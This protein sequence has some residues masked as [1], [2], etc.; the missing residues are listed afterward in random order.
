M[1]RRAT[2]RRLLTIP[3]ALGLA[4][5]PAHRCGAQPSVLAHAD[6]GAA[7][8]LEEA[9]ILYRHRDDLASAR[10]AAELWA[11]R[12]TVS[13]DAAWKLARVYYWLG[14]HD[15]VDDRRAEL[16][17]GVAAGEAAIRLDPNRPEGHFWTAANMGALAESYGLIQGLKYRG[18]IKDELE[19]VIA[20]DPSW[21]EGSADAALGQWYFEVPRLFGG[22]RAKAEEHLRRALAYDSQS[23]VALSF[24]ADVLVADGRRDEALRAL[25]QVV[26][27]PTDP[28]WIPED[29]DL[30]RKAEERLK[31][32]GQ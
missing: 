21:Q 13:Y 18:R 10:R 20:I 7:A 26:N 12:A 30:K 2:A 29:T 11:A 8:G 31:T 22:S 17:R 4:W 27:A 3:L 23:R 14:G 6:A 25:Q 9:D 1:K 28:D 5:I 24:L 19:R 16:E 32:L 15:A